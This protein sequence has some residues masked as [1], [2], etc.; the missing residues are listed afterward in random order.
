MEKIEFI[1]SIPPIQSAVSVSG[2]QSARIKLDVPSSELPEVLK[3]MAFY[4]G[5]A[6][7]VTIS[8]E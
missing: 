5:K 2:E 8:E 1:A 3:L 6:F 4:S 7:R